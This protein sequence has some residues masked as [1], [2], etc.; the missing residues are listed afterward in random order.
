M[1]ECC[2]YFVFWLKMSVFNFL[3]K[4]QCRLKNIHKTT[5]IA[6]LKTVVFDRI[7]LQ[8]MS[9]LGKTVNMKMRNN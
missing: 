3:T 1:F 5:T 6:R 9:E 4:R 7:C 2:F 8:R